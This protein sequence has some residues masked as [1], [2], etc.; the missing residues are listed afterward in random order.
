M[1]DP[2]VPP[3][4]DASVALPAVRDWVEAHLPGT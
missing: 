2:A 3:G 4:A 1:S